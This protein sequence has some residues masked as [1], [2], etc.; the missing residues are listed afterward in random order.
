VKELSLLSK[1][2]DP[3]AAMLCD[4]ESTLRI[5]IEVHWAPELPGSPPSTANGSTKG[6]VRFE[7]LYALVSGIRN[8]DGA[9]RGDGNADR[10]SKRFISVATP[11]P[12]GKE[13]GTG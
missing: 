3:V 6:P 9:F 5:D 4:V 2:L 12:D 7:Y 10:L 8:E 11:F 1:Y 13:F